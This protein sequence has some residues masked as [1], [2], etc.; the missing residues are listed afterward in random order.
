MAQCHLCTTN[1]PGTKALGTHGPLDPAAPEGKLARHVRAEGSLPVMRRSLGHGAVCAYAFCA[2]EP[3]STRG[4]MMCTHV[5][6]KTQKLSR[7]SSGVKYV[8]QNN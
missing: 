6:S 3:F 2:T 1:G 8:F 4:H 5:Q 7:K